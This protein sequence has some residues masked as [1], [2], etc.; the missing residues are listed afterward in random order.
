MTA[1]VTVTAT[2]LRTAIL[3]HMESRPPLTAY[4]ISAEMRQRYPY[5]ATTPPVQR[6]LEALE[7]AGL[8][9]RVLGQRT[10]T[11]K[12]DTVRWEAAP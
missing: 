3:A 12:R 10:R 11:D 2:V 8:V 4:A 1:P 6:A 5:G 7:R 9:R